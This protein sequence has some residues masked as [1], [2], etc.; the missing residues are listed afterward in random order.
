MNER[1]LR[2]ISVVVPTTSV[3]VFELFT[4]VLFTH[5][6]PMWVNLVV[7]FAGVSVGAS[8]FSA[9][10]FGT[11]GR[12]ESELRE[13]NRRL[14]LLNAV[15][16]EAS[17]SLDLDQVASAITR[18]VMQALTTDA[19][20]LALVSEEDGELRLVAQSGLPSNI[21]DATGQLGPYDCECRK[22]LIRGQTI[23]AADSR[24]NAAWAGAFPDGPAMS[25]LSAPIRSKGN[26]IGVILVAR[27]IS[28]PL[29]S[30]D[31]DLMTALG[32][33]VGPVLQ[34]AQ[35]FS[36]S[37]AIAVLQERQRVAREVHDGL[38]QTM[39][40]LNVQMG[41]TGHLLADRDL[42]KAQA[43]LEA[44]SRVTRD[45]YEDL[46]QSIGDLRAPLSPHGDLRR[47]LREYVERFSLQT[48]VPCHF[49]NQRDSALALSASA[50]VQLF[51]IVQEAL[52]NVKKHAPGARAWLSLKTNHRQVC[53][54]IQD[55]GPGFDPA[56]VGRSGRFGLQTIKE[57][58]E[59]VGGSF[60]IESRP[61]AG[62]R[63]QVTIPMEGVRA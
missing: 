26:N 36:K 24:E 23:V 33:Q 52:T 30:D 21:A 55:D 35:L 20:G 43:E 47:T 62:T 18:N 16:T 19:A 38:A 1:T 2:W 17:E 37:G 57:R 5:S 46:R 56:S 53:A 15:A 48:G 9:F 59:S 39:G 49:E 27:R 29:S 50:E 34:N 60:V 13:R 14:A 28:R 31:V 40:Y 11:M 45:A 63:L 32:R 54:T 3:V 44:M 8:A 25:C 7:A 41:I 42:E 51:R 6:V 10:V 22:A 61:G 58:A 12:L 4:H